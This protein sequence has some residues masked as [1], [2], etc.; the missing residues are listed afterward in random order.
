MK[1]EIINDSCFHGIQTHIWTAAGN[2]PKYTLV[3]TNAF[4]Y[5]RK[6]CCHFITAFHHVPAGIFSSDEIDLNM[7]GL[8]ETD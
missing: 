1:E 7:D 2:H 3:V 8:D 5:T 6:H 4:M